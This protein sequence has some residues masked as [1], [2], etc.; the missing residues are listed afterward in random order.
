MRRGTPQ[1]RRQVNFRLL[2]P[3]YDLVE[4][5]A[6]SLGDDVSGFCRRAVRDA[7]ERY[8]PSFSDRLDMLEARADKIEALL[9]SLAPRKSDS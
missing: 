7:L 5:V 6:R 8:G 2:E 3:E 9:A 4:S 1:R